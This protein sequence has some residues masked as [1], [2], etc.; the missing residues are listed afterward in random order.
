LRTGFR[1]IDIVADRGPASY[2]PHPVF[3]VPFL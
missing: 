1:G 3:Q 2:V